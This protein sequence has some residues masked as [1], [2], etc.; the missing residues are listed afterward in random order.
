MKIENDY[1]REFKQIL[2]LVLDGEADER[3]TAFFTDKVQHCT[4][5]RNLYEIEKAAQETIKKHLS[6]RVIPPS[7][8]VNDIQHQISI[9]T[10]AHS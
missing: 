2:P 5:C 8:L 10:K 9:L 4:H 6:H 3:V 7:E 1:R